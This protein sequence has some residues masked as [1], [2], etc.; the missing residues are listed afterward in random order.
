MA[1]LKKRGRTWYIEFS[2]TIDGKQLKRKFSLGTHN[3]I[4]AEKL[5]ARFTELENTGA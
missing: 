3:K 2:T 5:R 1:G 4:H